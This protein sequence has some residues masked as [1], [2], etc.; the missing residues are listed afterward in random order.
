MSK[1]DF[2]K[3]AEVVVIAG[4]E[5]GKRGKITAILAPKARRTKAGRILPTTSAA[6]VVIEGVNIAKHHTKKQGTEEGG[7]LEKEA[8]L[9]RSNVVLASDFDSRKQLS[10]GKKPA[11]AKK[12]K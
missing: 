11:Q 2:K 7:I 4:S 9:D 3:G 1:K 12:A 6:R 10:A 5:K 8:P